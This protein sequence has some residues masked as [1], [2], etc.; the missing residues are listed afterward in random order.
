M[1]TSNRFLI[2][3]VILT[4]LLQSHLR[5]QYS[6]PFDRGR[7]YVAVNF[8]P[9]ILYEHPEK[10]S[11]AFA[12]TYHRAIDRVGYDSLIFLKDSL[13]VSLAG[14][15]IA[16]AYNELYGLPILAFSP[17]SSWVQISLDCRQLEDPPSAWLN[18][19]DARQEGVQMQLW[20]TFFSPDEA[21]YF[22]DSILFYTEPNES[23]RASPVL[24]AGENGPDYCMRV[25]TTSGDWM[26][27]YL[28]TP[29][30]FMT[31]EEVRH[32]RYNTPKAPPKF[33]IKYLNR[34]GRPLIWYM[35]D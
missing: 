27:V 22:L 6:G 35:W 5:S 8:G 17:D 15:K 12:R 29:S 4:F 23:A 3:I 28:E 19:S 16:V 18:V 30:T 9:L 11:I 21:V 33:W 1:S 34:T 31:D 13:S 25:L 2:H 7:G 26:H 20:S 10:S 32:A 14:R 24:I